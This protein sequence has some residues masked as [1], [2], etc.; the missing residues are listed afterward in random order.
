MSICNIKYLVV[1]VAIVVLGSMDCQSQLLDRIQKAL[2][3]QESVD[4]A[5]REAAVVDSLQRELELVRQREAYTRD[6]MMQLRL[7]YSA[8]SSKR[9]EQ[10]HRIDSLR[11]ITPGV[12]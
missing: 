6:E 9:E 2:P 10:R 7:Y 1:L 12:P 8:D 4:S 3:Q 11:K 5:K